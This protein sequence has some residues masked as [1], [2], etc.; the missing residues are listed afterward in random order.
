MIERHGGQI[1]VIKKWDER[2]L[3]YEI[4]GQKRGTYIIAFYR[5]H[6]Q[7]VAILL[8]NLLL[9]W[10]FLGLS[11]RRVGAART[12]VL[13]GTTPL[14][15]TAI[16]FL[17]LGELVR[18]TAL[19]GVAL[20][21]GGIFLLSATRISGSAGESAGAGLTFGLVTALCWGVSPVFVRWGLDQVPVPLIGVT[22]G[23][24]ASAAAYGLVLLVR[25]QRL[26]GS[27]PSGAWGWLGAAGALV[28]LGIGSLWVALSLAPVAV[29][30]ALNQLAVLTVIVTAPFIVGGTAEKLTLWTG[31]GAL[32]V[33]TGTLLIIF[34]R[35]PVPT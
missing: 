30:L 15:G 13:I 35:T 17:V 32:L 26:R 27:V 31:A 29:V 5:G 12:G 8:L 1:I 6:H 24:A 9:G 16:A 18:P 33:L 28:A 4:G 34:A 2:R 21:V 11:Q 23:M 19:A 20:V 3:A 22:V 14:F 25:R 10:T 7:S